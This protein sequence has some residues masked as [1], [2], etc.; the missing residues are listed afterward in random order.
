MKL[1]FLVADE[2]TSLVF[3][4]STS[5][6]FIIVTSLLLLF[7]VYGISFDSIFSK[8]LVY[9]KHLM[10]TLLFYQKHLILKIVN[11]FEWVKSSEGENLSACLNF[12]DWENSFEF[13]ERV[14]SL[15]SKDS[16]K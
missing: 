14:D 6:V 16:E 5:L 12:S 10:K 4:T 8:Y 15:N 1:L 2:S 11:S 7:E 3:V 13:E 9:Q